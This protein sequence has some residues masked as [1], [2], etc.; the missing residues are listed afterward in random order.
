MC[1]RDRQYP[2]KE[3]LIKHNIEECLAVHVRDNIISKGVR[4]DGRGADDIRKITAEI[5]ILPR[6]HGS[7]LFTRGETQS[8]ATVTLGTAHDMQIM[9]DL[10]GEYKERFMLHY[11][12]PG[13]ATGE[14][15]ADRGPGRREIGHGALAK[16]AL[17]PIMPDEEE[18][19]YTTRVVSEI[20]ESN[21]SSSMASVC[22]GSLSLFDAGVPVKTAVAGIAMGLVT[23]GDKYRV[24]TDIMGSEDHF[25]DMDFKAAGTAEGLTA[26]Q[27]DI[28]VGG[29]S[30]QIIQDALEKAKAARLKI[31]DIMN[32]AIAQPK[33]ELSSF[34]PRIEVVTI[35]QDKIGALIGPGGKNIRR[36]IDESQAEIEVDDD[37][38]VFISSDNP[39]SMAIAR[40]MVESLTAEVE[41]GKV[42]NGKVVKIA[43]FGAFVEL[44]PGKDGLLHISQI[45]KKRVE[46]VEDVL[47][48]GD[49]VKVKVLE[50]DSQGKVSLSCKEIEQ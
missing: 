5:G 11:N 19:P 8:L 48:E 9:D 20:L 26:L 33:A 38:R 2:E 42:Y 24:L 44:I 39:D 28:K 40:E 29:L 41:V 13:F 34:A 21:G 10:E 36:I 3:G 30:I 23:D 22:A 35:P 27:M 25:G 4:V 1:I 15:K 16:R 14:P 43:K 50:V 7:S 49:P 12:F 31:L 32:K 46:K 47:K 45:S 37:G 18:F 17:Y 6:T